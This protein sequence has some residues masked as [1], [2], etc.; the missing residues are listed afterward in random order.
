[1]N[2]WMNEWMKLTYVRW[3][4]SRR[5]IE[6]DLTCCSM[7]FTVLTNNCCSCGKKQQKKTWRSLLFRIHRV[8]YQVFATTFISFLVEVLLL[9]VM[10]KLKH[11]NIFKAELACDRSRVGRTDRGSPSSLALHFPPLQRRNIFEI[12]ENRLIWSPFAKCPDLPHDVAPPSRMSVSPL[13]L[14]TIQGSSRWLFIG[15]YEGISSGFKTQQEENIVYSFWLRLCPTL[16]SAIKLT[17]WV[18]RLTVGI[19]GIEREGQ[20]SA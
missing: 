16:N 4:V 17:P 13:E 2:E 14:A 7:L 15:L 1:M 10:N 11:R 6:S 8:T 9:H 5:F 3:F 19:S 20:S 18:C 12:L